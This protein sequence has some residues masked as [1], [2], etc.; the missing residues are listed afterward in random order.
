MSLTDLLPPD[1][2]CTFET[3]LTIDILD[4]ELDK[5]VDEQFATNIPC[6]SQGVEQCAKMVR[7][8]SK[9]VPCHCMD[10]RDGYIRA[11]L[12]SRRPMPS[13]TSMHSYITN[14]SG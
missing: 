11:V 6:H 4:A 2:E 5:I 1:S 8:A 14:K 7:E 3:P 9:A 13:N 10:A 12:K